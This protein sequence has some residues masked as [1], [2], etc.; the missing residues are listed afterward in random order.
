MKKETFADTLASCLEA[1]ER[2]EQTVEE[3]LNRYPAHR[4]ELETLLETIVS[5]RERANFA[6]RPSFQLSSR[7]R[8]LRRLDGGHRPLGGQPLR[9]SK[10]VPIQKL[11]RKYAMFW[12]IVLVLFVS[13]LGGGT[14]HASKGTLPGDALYPVKLSIED[15]HLLV[16]NDA[17][18][19]LLA[20]E[21]IQRRVEEIQALIAL[22]RNDDL[23][24]A[25]S[26]LAGR[27]SLATD[28]LAVIERKDPEQA[29]QLAIQ[30]ESSLRLHTKNLT[31]QLEIAPNEAKPAIEQAILASR[32]GQEVVRDMFGTNL[33]APFVTPPAGLPPENIPAPTVTPPAGVPSPVENPTGG[34]PENIP[35]PVT[36][37]G[38]GPPKDIPGPPGGRP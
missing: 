30:L 23:P 4:D 10:R 32:S 29:A 36:P 7:A 18:K 12:A 17:E 38:G 19:T 3:C 2:G 27:V 35:A 22:E 15:V 24:L 9:D 14:V 28:T 8:L 11:S 37:P 33:P 1:I 20:V 16:S 25:A 6:P 5:I 13:L 31:F 21:F 34:P 26:L